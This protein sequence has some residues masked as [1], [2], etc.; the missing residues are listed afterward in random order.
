MKISQ[1]HIRNI[2][3]PVLSAILLI[4]PGFSV[5]AQPTIT[6]TTGSFVENCDAWISVGDI[7]VTENLTD[8]FAASQTDK[9]YK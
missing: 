5:Y 7:V 3:I 1:K 8:D 6:K 4:L 9:T 2:L